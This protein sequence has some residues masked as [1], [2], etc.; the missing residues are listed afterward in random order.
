[1]EEIKKLTED[2]ILKALSEV[3]DP[4]IPINIVDLGLIYKVDI[5]DNNDVNVDMT[6][7][8]MGCPMH[9][10]IKEQAR[11]RI[12]RI[13]GI[14]KVNVNLVWEPKWTPERI[15]KEVREK[16]SSSEE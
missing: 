2:D 5:N 15:S 4:E 8:T 9:M 7:T 6:F 14:G 13:Q 11:E 10:Y 3:Y 1:M 12:E 16:L